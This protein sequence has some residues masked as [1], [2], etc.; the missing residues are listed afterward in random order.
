MKILIFSILISVPAHAGTESMKQIPV[1]KPQKTYLIPSNIAG[2][3]LL[4]E[5]GFGKEESK[6][7]M[8]NL[9]MVEGSGMEGMDMGEAKSAPSS[10]IVDKKY[11]VK[12]ALSHAA[13]LGKN[14]YEFI[15]EDKITHEAVKNLKI[16]A[17][18]KMATMNMGI[19][20]PE[21]IELANKYQVNI[22]FS[23][24]GDWNLFLQFPN[25]EVEKI[26]FIAE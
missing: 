14:I 4:N 12:G 5:R 19:E 1:L 20:K 6:I 24:A 23:M 15:V 8:M 13:T 18:V 7:K 10:K 9:M 17:S 22:S 25:G 11:L 26:N 21:V 2:E 16:N 3:K